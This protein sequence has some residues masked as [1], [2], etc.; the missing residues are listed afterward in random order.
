[1][2]LNEV[3]RRVRSFL[4]P[5]LLILCICLVLKLVYTK[6]EIYFAVNSLNN[7]LTDFLAPYITD[8]GNGWTAIIIATLFALFSYR[9]AFL[10][11]SAYGLTALSAQ[12]LKYI[13]DTP[14]PMLYFKNQL[15]SIHL[16]KGVRDVA[17]A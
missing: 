8:L 12:L 9:K 17:G 15:S 11:A 4:I 2:S 6:P 10:L 1:M 5:Y 7:S 13:F 16:V 14:R 3:F